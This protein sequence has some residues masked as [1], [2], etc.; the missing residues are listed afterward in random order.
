MKRLKRV[1]K[2]AF[3]LVELITVIAITSILLGLIL[4]P[5]VQSFNLTRAAQGYT[6]AQQKGRELI[7][8]I[9]REIGNGAG[10][11]DNDGVRGQLAVVI[12]GGDGTPVSVLLDYAKVD[13]YRP[14]AG[15]PGLRGPGGGYINPNTGVEDPTIKAPIGQPSL[16]V[17][18]GAT[19]TRYFIGLKDPL[20]PDDSPSIYYNPHVDYRRAGNVRW[21]NP[22]RE[23]NLVVL[24]RAEIPAF[25]PAPGGGFQTNPAFFRDVDGDGILDIDDP[26]FFT[27]NAPGQ[28]VLAGAA[29][30]NKIQIIKNWKRSAQIVTEFN[31]YDMIQPLINKANRNLLLDGNIPRV[32]SLIQFQ[33]SAVTNEP[34][35]GGVA[36]RLGEESDGMREYAPDIYRTRHAG[37]SGAVVRFYPSNYDPT[38]SALNEYL[39][40]RLDQRAGDRRWRIYC[41]DP[42]LDPDGDDRNGEDNPIDDLEVFDIYAFEQRIEAGLAYPFM[43]GVMA[44]NTRSGWLGSARGRNM[45]RA[46]LPNLAGG[47]LSTSIG[48]DQWGVDGTAILPPDRNLPFALTGPE[49]TPTNDPV[50]PGNFYDPAYDTINKKF[51]KVWLDNPSMQVAGGTHRFIDL[52]LT[53]SADGTLS[54]LH[55]IN[56]FPQATIVPGSEVVIGPDQ[57]PTGNYGQPIRYVRTTR[58]PGRNQYQ[59]NYSN[60]A[61]PNYAANGWA[62]PPATYDPTNFMS[63]IIQPRYKV[64]YLQFNSDPLA[65]LPTGTISVYY[66]VQFS[67]PGDTITVDY[68]TRDLMT[69]LLTIRNYPQTTLPNPQNITLKATAP[70]RNAVR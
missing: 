11:R 29:L 48:I 32:V 15:D 40:A 20:Q 49:L 41:Y 6:E 1:M 27:L 12:P 34:A 2:R 50:L 38:N 35:E 22:G 56:G 46:F 61:E 5:I 66:K 55:P 4:V 21:M 9:T 33:P 42:D 3:T 19:V 25:V 51:N 44:A 14:A 8:S 69:V 17:A 63:A 60:L 62:N 31:R 64:G 36:S 57:N 58:N 39:I 16:P 43:R 47:E 13:V 10:I 59:I 53:P 52:R 37:W 23:D 30:A 45:F 67:K 24:Y 28:P 7:E 68:D 54:P 65:A 26:Y 70:V 18:P